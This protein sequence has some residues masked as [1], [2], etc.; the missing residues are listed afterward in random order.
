[1]IIPV[2]MDKRSELHELIASHAANE[3]ARTLYCAIC[4]VPHRVGDNSPCPATA[5]SILALEAR[6]EWFLPKNVTDRFWTRYLRDLHLLFERAIL[7]ALDED[8]VGRLPGVSD[9]TPGRGSVALRSLVMARNVAYDKVAAYTEVLGLEADRYDDPV[10]R[11]AL[12]K[13]ITDSQ[14]LV[15]YDVRS[16]IYDEFLLPPGE[17]RALRSQ[18]GPNTVL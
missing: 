8:N 5:P 12:V 7:I 9:E 3:A 1:M 13:D 16:A 18:A 6:R 10:I 14:R 4:D 15:A 17:T 11:V 2:I